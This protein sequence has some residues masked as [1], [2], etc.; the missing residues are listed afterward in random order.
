MAVERLNQISECI[1]INIDNHQKLKEAAM[2]ALGSKVVSKYKEK[3]AE[4]ARDAVLEVAD[5]ERK[6]VNFD[7]I[8]ICN[9][10]GGSMEDSCLVNGI[11]LDKDISHP[12]MMK[13]FKDAKILLLT[14]AFEP[15]KPKTKHNINITSAEDY[16]KMYQQE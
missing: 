3:F 8:K 12:Q 10:T 2:T 11:V 13:E 9:K 14:C 6:D 5:L 4:I 15:P 7:L 16:K 1:D